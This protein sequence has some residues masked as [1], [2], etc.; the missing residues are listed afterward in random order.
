M[1]RE[2]LRKAAIEAVERVGKTEYRSR[3]AEFSAMIGL[4]DRMSDDHP[5]VREF[6]G[7]EY[8]HI[9]DNANQAVESHNLRRSMGFPEEGAWP[10]TDAERTLK[11]RLI[12]EL[13]K[14]EIIEY[15]GKHGH[16][17]VFI[18]HKQLEAVA[19]SGELVASG[20][21][22]LGL[23][24][25]PE[26]CGYAYFFEM[27]GMRVL[28]VFADFDGKGG[29]DYRETEDLGPIRGK[30]VLI[31][32]D[33]VQS[34]LTLRTVLGRLRGF[35]AASYGLY[36]GNLGGFQKTANVPGQI[37]RIH[38][39]DASGRFRSEDLEANLIEAL[40]KRLFSKYDVFAPGDGKGGQ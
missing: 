19:T 24:V 18:P 39:N 15:A 36:L 12:E 17:K 38:M 30:K 32:E 31:I 1:R 16:G 11:A 29:I 34:G 21:Y 26:G 20:R 14:D 5:T 23:S 33:D 37:R 8:G 27:Q 13:L 10:V 40:G 2:A 9:L 22:D 7:N 6:V 4:L 28:H 25:E 3:A 35:K